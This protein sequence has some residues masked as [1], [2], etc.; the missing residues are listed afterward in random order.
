MQA[1]MHYATFTVIYLN[2]FY[3]KHVSIYF[4]F[5]ALCKTI[6]VWLAQTKILQNANV[7]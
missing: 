2:I 6:N 5:V 7:E 3:A 1:R 4:K